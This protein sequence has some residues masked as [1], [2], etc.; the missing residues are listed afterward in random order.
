MTPQIGDIWLWCGEVHLLV[1]DHDPYNSDYTCIRLETG[2]LSNW[3]MAVDD[4]EEGVDW[5]MLA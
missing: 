3:L 5:E 4:P 1:I 2:K